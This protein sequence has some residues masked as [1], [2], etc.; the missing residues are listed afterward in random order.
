MMVL[1]LRTPV[2]QHSDRPGVVGIIGYDHSA[3][4]IRPEVLSGV[5]A[6]ATHVRQAPGP[7]PLVLGTVRL[8]S[9]LDH[10]EAATPSDLQDRGHVSRLPIQVH[11]DDRFRPLRDGGFDDLRVDIERLR[12]DVDEHRPRTG[13]ADRRYR[14]DKREWNGDDLVAWADV[15]GEQREVKGARP[16]VDA[17]PM[18]RPAIGS[19]LGLERRN[20]GS[21]RELAGLEYALDR[22]VHL[23]LD[24]F[25]L[26][27]QIDERNQAAFS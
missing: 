26:R 19:E 6:K 1:P 12:I 20:L 13:V 11:R 9:I 10:R 2:A 7:T 15:R 5:E 17:D 4:A 27:L 21:E 25:V 18:L 16:R 23:V 22:G 24:R 14:R 8:T 3:F